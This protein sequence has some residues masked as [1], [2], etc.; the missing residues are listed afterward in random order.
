[1]AASENST[2]IILGDPVPWF[3]ARSSSATA[4]CNLHVAC[5]PL[6]RAVVLSVRPPPARAGRTD[7]ASGRQ[8]TTV[9]EDKMSSMPCSPRRRAIS[10][11]TA[12]SG[13]GSALSFIA[14][15]DL[16]PSPR[17]SAPAA[18]RAPW[19]SIQC[20]ARSRC[21]LGSRPGHGAIAR[22]IFSTLPK[23]T[24]PPACTAHAPV[25]IVP[26]VLDF[27]LCDFLNRLLRQNRRRGIPGFCSTTKARPAP[28]STIAS[29]AVAICR[30][31]CRSVRERIR[32][33]LV[34]RLL[35]AIERFF[36]SMRR[37]WIAISSP[38]TTATIGGHFHRHR[39]NRQ[40]RRRASP[41]RGLDQSQPRL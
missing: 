20:C 15:Y 24:K 35:P 27:Q 11:I 7:R 16:A 12:A 1:M 3:S 8:I 14:D 41:L 31:S 38:V 19:Y 28:S 34:S 30:S 10:R 17:L 9:S 6:D 32:I 29:S 23:S 37:G 4:S 21:S 22:A 26:R 39:D 40:C 18:C 25:L 2:R 33:Q 36:N 5:R 13:T